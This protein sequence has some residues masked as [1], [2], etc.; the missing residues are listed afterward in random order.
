MRTLL[1]IALLLLV[2]GPFRRRLLA[3]WRVLA[4]AV[5]GA[6]LG[7]MLAGLFV[8][9]GGPAWLLVF[10]PALFALQLG[11]AGKAWLDRALRP[12]QIRRH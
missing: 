5:L 6:A 7:Y 8:R 1:A 11:A 12:S 3:N 9:S 10:A 2:V 4:P